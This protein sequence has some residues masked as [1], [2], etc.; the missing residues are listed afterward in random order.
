MM[1][2]SYTNTQDESR[3]SF[4]SWVADRNA[5]VP[6]ALRH[7]I[8]DEVNTLQQ[9]IP[10]A[11]AGQDIEGIHRVRVTIRRTRTVLKLGLPYFKKKI[12]R[13]IRDELKRAGWVFGAVRDLDV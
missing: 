3:Q 1:I 6:Q 11:L 12:I 13:T 4:S 2:D 7:V 5:S 10:V 9:M 8:K